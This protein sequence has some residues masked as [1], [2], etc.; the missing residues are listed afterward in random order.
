MFRV[1]RQRGRRVGVKALGVQQRLYQSLLVQVD[2]A[3][4]NAAKRKARR[5]PLLVHP[6][7]QKTGTGGRRRAGA[8]LDGKTRF[9][10]AGMGYHVRRPARYQQLARVAGHARRPHADFRRVAHFLHRHHEVHLVLHDAGRHVR[11]RHQAFRQQHH[12]LRVVRVHHRVAQRPAARFPRRAVGVAEFVAARHPEER[13]VYRQLP[14]LQQVHPPA[15][16]VDLHRLFHQPVRNRVRQLAAHAGG[17]DT[18]NHP[19]ADVLDQR[20]V[21]GHQR[22]RRQRQVL[23]AQPGQRVH[24]VVDHLV[25]FTERVVERNRH[26]VLQPALADGLL[27]VGTQLAPVFFG[28]VIQPGGTVVGTDERVQRTLFRVLLLQCFN[29]VTHALILSLR[30]P[31]GACSR[32][33]PARAESV[34]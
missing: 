1:F 7:F 2:D 10:V 8:G 6:V 19:V 23:K 31:A 25:P 9:E 15:V 24:H 22:A 5:H 26:P 28:D 12:R 3:A 17:V 20:R 30:R 34:G 21:A 18:A 29:K 27:Q 32:H 16:R 4:G 13:H 33:R 14:A 11:E